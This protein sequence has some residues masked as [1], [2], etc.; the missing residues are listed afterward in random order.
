MTTAL[1]FCSC[2]N[3]FFVSLMLLHQWKKILMLVLWLLSVFNL[4]IIYV[5]ESIFAQQ[6]PAI[7]WSASISN[8]ISNN[9]TFIWCFQFWL[10][11]SDPNNWISLMLLHQRHHRFFF[12]FCS[13]SLKMKQRNRPQIWKISTFEHDVK[14]Q[15]NLLL[16]SN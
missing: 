16:V 9:A 2:P 8:Q 5:F 15:K 10:W 7:D 13:K 14:Q 4:S 6:I 11:L 12:V 3:T 1:W